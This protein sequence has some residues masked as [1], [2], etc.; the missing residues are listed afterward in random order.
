MRVSGAAGVL[1]RGREGATRGHPRDVAAVPSKPWRRPCTRRTRRGRTQTRSSARPGSPSSRPNR[2]GRLWRRR[3]ALRGRA[4][5]RNPVGHDPPS[6]R[7]DTSS[8]PRCR[9]SALRGRART[10][11]PVGPGPP[12]SRPGRSS[13]PPC[14]R[15]P[16]RTP[17]RAAPTPRRRSPCSRSSLY[18]VVQQVTLHPQRAQ[19]PPHVLEV[20]GIDLGHLGQAARGWRPPLTELR[21]R[22]ERAVLEGVGGH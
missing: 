20:R 6:S 17:P 22:G 4:R 2:A 1:V 3:S 5:T 14:T 8:R 9:R 10:R 15:R 11:N 12:S 7:P 13:P 18:R 21:R 19:A 16:R